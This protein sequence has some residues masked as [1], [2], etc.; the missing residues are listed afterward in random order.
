MLSAQYFEKVLSEGEAEAWLC[1]FPTMVLFSG[2]TQ[3]AALSFK[4]RDGQLGKTVLMQRQDKAQHGFTGIVNREGTDLE[5]VLTKLDGFGLSQHEPHGD[6]Q[7]RQHVRCRPGQG[8]ES[9]K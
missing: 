2:D 6:C 3:L 4:V 9:D 1:R 5:F 7:Q 8:F